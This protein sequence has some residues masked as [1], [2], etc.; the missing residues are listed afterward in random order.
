MRGKHTIAVFF[1]LKKAYD[2]T[3]KHGI[4]QKLHNYG[5]RGHLPI[6]ITF[7]LECRKIQVRVGAQLSDPASIDEGVPQGSVL[8]CTLFAVAIDDA[9][10]NLPPSVKATLY[11]DDLTI[12]SSARNERVAKRQIQI[13]INT[14]QN[15]CSRTGF[16]F[17]A[18]KTVSMHICRARWGA[19]CCLKKSPELFLNGL[20]IANKDQ[21]LYLGLVID[22]SLTWN[23]HIDYVKKDCQ[24]RLN[25]MKHVS[26][27]TWG[28]DSKSLLRIYEAF[29][30]SKLEY[31]VEAYGSACDSNLKNL[32]PSKIRLSELLLGRTEHPLLRA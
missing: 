23:G 22:K 13:A 1:D 15:W 17:K 25:V 4:L 28:A 10:E 20:E 12:Y 8:S 3:W 29:V 16:C 30:K 32:G 21:H 2:T 14:L 5:L 19:Q 24:R 26:H 27:E 6:F 11:V 9:V 18:E 7:F 31:G